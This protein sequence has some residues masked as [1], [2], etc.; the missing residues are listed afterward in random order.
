MYL[1]RFVDPRKDSVIYARRMS[2]VKVNFAYA[3]RSTIDA[4]ADINEDHGNRAAICWRSTLFRASPILVAARRRHG[5]C[6]Q[7]E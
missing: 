6:D 5:A 2:F 4:E 3:F 7:P 1:R